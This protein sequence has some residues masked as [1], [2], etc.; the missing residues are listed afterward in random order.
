LS[1]EPSESEQH[2]P[3]KKK[4]FGLKCPRCRTRYPGGDEIVGKRLRCPTCHHVWRDQ[5]PALRDAKRALEQVADHWAELDTTAIAH[6]DHASTFGQLSKKLRKRETFPPSDWIGKRVGRYTIKAV[7]GQGAMGYVYEGFDTDLQRSV[8]IKLL[9]RAHGVGQNETIGEKLFIQE[10]RLAAKLQHPNVV[11][12]YDF[13]EEQGYRYFAMELVRGAT[14]LDLVKAQGPLPVTQGCY[15]IAH[16]AR[17]LAAG[18]QVGIIHRDVKPGNIMLNESG[19]VKLTDFGLAESTS[20]EGEDI[21]EG[22]S[23]GTPGWISPEVANRQPALKESDIYG[24]GLTLYFALTGKRFINGSSR[25]DLIRKQRAAKEV[26]IAQLP[27]DWPARLRQIVVQCLH[28]DPQDR[29]HDA[30]L[31]AADLVRAIRPD[32]RDQTVTLD[33]SSTDVKLPRHATEPKPAGNTWILPTV[34]TGILVA[35][36]AIVAWALRWLG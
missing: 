20:G 21:T 8:A 26:D 23:L 9:P 22:I 30:N 24:L 18:H 13:G 17:A 14:L 10:A 34:M 5:R 29:Y 3:G 35:L 16:A 25:S 27:T 12:V 33:M 31:L 2:G 28:V 1:Q 4:S 11:T 19:V 6:V 36:I 32:S 7:L 15:I